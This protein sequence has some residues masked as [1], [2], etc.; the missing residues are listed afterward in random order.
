[1]QKYKASIA[2]KVRELRIQRHWTQSELASHLGLS[3]S[4]LSEIERGGGSFTAEQFV[5]VLQLFN[6]G[7]SYFVDG[8][9]STHSQL[10]NALARLGAAHLRESEDVVPSERLDEVNRVVVEVLIDG[11]A[12]LVTALAPVLVTNTDHIG[13]RRIES[14][15]ATLG[16]ESRLGWLVENVEAAIGQE[17]SGPLATAW[18]KQY[19]RAA[20][21]LAQFL[22]SATRRL[23]TNESGDYDLPADILDSSI[24][25]S[26]TLA[27]TTAARSRI[28]Q[29]WNVITALEPGDFGQALRGARDGI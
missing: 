28:S 7:V 9:R 3:Q 21:Q 20:V 22:E 24:R 23:P 26:S 13:L 16:L 17:L 15:L 11:S 4:R 8:V 27:E 18:R 1:M 5:L 10:H 19:Q 29:R 25:S 6:V 12:R 2:A 14:E